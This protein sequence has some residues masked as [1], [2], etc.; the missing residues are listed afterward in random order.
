MSVNTA[1]K[2]WATIPK[3]TLPKYFEDDNKAELDRILR[4]DFVSEEF[5]DRRQE[6]VFIGVDIDE[7]AIRE[8]LDKCLLSDDELNTYRQ[9]LNNFQMATMTAMPTTTSGGLFDVDGTEHLDQ[10]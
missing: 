10:K 5:G 9:Q 6:L 1:G 2:W 3:K 4:E 7:P 8:A